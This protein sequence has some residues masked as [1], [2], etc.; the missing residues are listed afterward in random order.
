MKFSVVIVNYASWP[1]T[2]RCVRSFYRTNYEDFE[3]VVVDNDRSEPPTLPSPVRLIRNPKNVGFAKACNQGIAASKGDL[4]V[5]INP[6]TVVSAGFF[7][8]MGEFFESDYSVG[9]AGPR[10]LDPGGG[11]QLSARKELS[12]VS[13]L[14]GRTSFLT[15]LFPKSSLVKSQ[16]P[17]VTES[18]Y[19]TA[20]DW[21]SGACMVI[22]RETLNEVGPLDDRFFMYFEDADLCRRAREAGWSVYYL[23]EVVVVHRAGGSSRSQPRAIWRLHKSA[24]LYHRKHGAHGPL[25]LYSV[26]AI[27]GLTLRGLV[28]LA[29]SLMQSYGRR[30]H[31]RRTPPK[32]D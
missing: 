32:Q 9:V 5:L 19:P 3:V 20:V 28:K 2:V 27:A 30:E 11:L 7:D 26:L 23:P 8:R 17:S 29:V 24:F 22:R 21:V 13:G 10:V 18:T 14:L 15:G 12:M 31:F 1:L 25:S 16:F 4:L 6:D